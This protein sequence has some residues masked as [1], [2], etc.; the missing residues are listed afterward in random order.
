[1][2]NNFCDRYFLPF[3][4]NEFAIHRTSSEFKHE[5]LFVTDVFCL[6]DQINW[7][8]FLIRKFENESITHLSKIQYN[9]SDKK[10]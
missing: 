10:E 3:A 5:E 9:I 2:E 4:S 7:I 6:S 8:F 1:M